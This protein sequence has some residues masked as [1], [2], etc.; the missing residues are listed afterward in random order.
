MSK[1]EINILI[2][3]DEEKIANIIA[4]YLRLYKGFNK[5]IIANDGVQAVQKISNQDF[6]LVITDLVMPKRDG[7]ALIDNIQKVPKYNNIKFIVVSGCL[8]KEMTIAAMKRGI[9]HIVVKPFTARQII[10]KTFDA[11]KIV[12]DL[13]L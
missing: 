10:E 2:V 5:I 9:K 7:L 1:K 8:N 13:K 3:D 4:K 12:N 6:D 11:L